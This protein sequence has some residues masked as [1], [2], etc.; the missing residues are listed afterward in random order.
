MHDIDGPTATKIIR[1]KNVRYSQILIIAVTS[2]I[3]KEDEIEIEIEIEI[4]RRRKIG[5][6]GVFF[7]KIFI[8]KFKK[9]NI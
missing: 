2:S 1:S 4:E 9:K 7:N 3:L 6:G 8:K 5:R